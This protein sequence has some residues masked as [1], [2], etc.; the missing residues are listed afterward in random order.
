MR[1]I[2]YEEARQLD[3]PAFIDV[4]SPGEFSKDHIPGSV[5]IPILGDE[6]REEI[7][8][9]YHLLGRDEAITRGGEIVGSKLGEIITDIGRLKDRD[10]IINCSRGGMRSKSL[11]AL[12][13]SLDFN[14]YKLKDGYK[15]YRRYILSRIN[16]IGLEPPVF[17][18]QGLTGTGKTEILRRIENA[19]DLEQLAGHRS[20]VFGGMGLRQ[21]TQKFFESL[22]IERIDE[23]ND[24]EYVVIEGESRKIGNLHIPEGIMH[25]IKNSAT[26]LIRASIERRVEIILNEY[27]GNMDS[28]VLIEIVKSLESRIG[29]K[30]VNNLIELFER[31]DLFEF[32]RLILEK[33][34]DPLYRHSI[35]R[36]RFIAEVENVDTESACREVEGV[37]LNYLGNG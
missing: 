24:R 3:S 27:T 7:G 34:Y 10:I 29:L 9:I 6:E 31:G 19:I 5:N 36:M 22:L 14:V 26:I 16:D 13:L 2:T 32:A 30:N 33:Y 28:G 4:R 21:N 17:V 8:K 12:L 15:G 23:L 37:I 18:L 25:I 20:S 35:A 11:V 1:E